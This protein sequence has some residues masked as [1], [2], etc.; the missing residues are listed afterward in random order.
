MPLM[1]VCMRKSS[2]LFCLFI[3]LGCA[4]LSDSP[5]REPWRSGGKPKRVVILVFDQLRPDFIERF[6]LPQFQRLKKH[7]L[8]FERAWVGHLTSNTI[9]SHPVITSGLS[10]KHLPWSDEVFLDK[11]GALGKKGEFY[12]NMELKVED[13]PKIWGKVKPS[14]LSKIPGPPESKFVVAQKHYAAFGFGTPTTA[15]RILTLGPK[16][17]EDPLKGWREPVGHLLLQQFIEPFGGRFFLDANPSYGTDKTVYPFDGN[18]YAKG[19]D[20]QHFGGDIWVADSALSFFQS[21]PNWTAAFISFGALDKTLHALGEHEESTRT[22]WALENGLDLKTVLLRADEQ[23]GRVLDYLES[24]DLLQETLVIATSDHGG[25]VDTEYYGLHSPIGN[26]LDFIEGK[27]PRES[28][29]REL[30]R[31]VKAGSVKA[32]VRDSALRFYLKKTDRISL[33]NFTS[34]V[35]KIPGVAEVYYRQEISGRSH[36]IRAFRSDKL[37]GASLDWAKSHHPALLQSLSS[38]TSADIVVLLLD[39]VGYGF[40]GDHGGAQ[41]KVQ[42]IPFFLWSPNLRTNTPTV[43]RQLEQIE[44]RLVDIHPL[45]LEL[46]GLPADSSLD[47]SSLG[48]SSLI[49][50]TLQE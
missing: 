17:S 45:V 39:G 11:E 15:S 13:F 27:T 2:F 1:S 25:Q 18:R 24:K 12:S 42:R 19:N 38:P 20:P 36:Y 46:M 34:S 3:L 40:P 43:R 10:P 6:S 50:P 35:R 14:L 48:I 37:Q 29:P 5:R 21:E 49:E 9:V 23:L 32:L 31:L 4:G 22:A 28:L 16:R 7:A 33:L 41:E 47:G 44:A 30:Q 8:Q 26:H